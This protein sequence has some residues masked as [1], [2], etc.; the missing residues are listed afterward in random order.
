MS[1]GPVHSASP[2]FGLEGSWS[3]IFQGTLQLTL[4]MVADPGTVGQVWKLGKE[5]KQILS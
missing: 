5:R 4:E 1:L 3:Q 2:V